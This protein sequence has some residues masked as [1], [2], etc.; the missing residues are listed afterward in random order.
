MQ[1][2]PSINSKFRHGTITAQNAHKAKKISAVALDPTAAHQ[3]ILELA[4]KLA[5]PSDSSFVLLQIAHS[6]AARLFGGDAVSPKI[7]HNK[8]YLQ[9]V[10][11]LY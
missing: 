10:I 6:W 4:A 9:S 5:L 3:A 8:A 7:Q 2:E 11:S 1:E